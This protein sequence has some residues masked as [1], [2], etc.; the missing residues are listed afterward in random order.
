MDFNSSLERI[1]DVIASMGCKFFVKEPEVAIDSIVW[2][3]YAN[4]PDAI[5]N[6]GSLLFS[7]YWKR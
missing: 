3:L 4:V 2:E 5:K 7:E 1:M 6:K